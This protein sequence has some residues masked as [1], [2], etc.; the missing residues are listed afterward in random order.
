[1]KRAL[2]LF[3]FGVSFRNWVNIFYNK[4]QS[5]VTNNGYSTCWFYLE[6][7]VRQGYPLSTALFIISI[8]LLAISVRKSKHIN[9]ISLPPNFEKNIAD[10][11]DDTTLL[12]SDLKSIKDIIDSIRRFT[13][14]SGLEI[15]MNKTELLFPGTSKRFWKYTGDL[16]PP[17]TVTSVPIKCLGIYIGQNKE[18][19]NKLNCWYNLKKNT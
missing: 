14:C 9:G 6:R 5:C 8:E 7:D 1:M 16:P 17:L 18:E 19:C 11:A 3:G 10:F 13:K 4:F 12:L 15:S 2:V